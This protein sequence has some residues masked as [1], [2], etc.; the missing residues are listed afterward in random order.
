MLWHV[1]LQLKK[2]KTQ[3]EHLRWR[4]L[5]VLPQYN[6]ASWG[7]CSLILRLHVLLIKFLFTI[8]WQN[9]VFLAWINWSRAF[10]L[11]FIRVWFIFEALSWK[12]ILRREKLFFVKSYPFTTLFWVNK[13]ENMSACNFRQ[14]IG[15]YI[16]HS[17]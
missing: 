13:D 6:K 10:D 14:L 5:T 11:P 17:Y 8:T 15:Q 9:N 3:L 7:V 2:K 16:S 1:D 12:V 4:L